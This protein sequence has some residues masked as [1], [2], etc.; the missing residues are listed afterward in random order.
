MKKSVFAVCLA[1]SLF[2]NTLGVFA[3]ETTGSVSTGVQTGAQ[4]VV[5]SE[6]SASPVAGTYTASQSVTLSATDA[7][8]L[9][10]TNDNTTP[11]CNWE[12]LS[13]TS[14]TKYSSALSLT[15]N[16]K[17]RAISCYQGSVSS[18]VGEYFYTIGAGQETAAEPS[19]STVTDLPETSGTSSATVTVSSATT[20]S[21]AA[22]LSDAVPS[23]GADVADS[24]TIASNILTIASS[25][26]ASN[27]VV[28]PAGTVITVG[29]G[30][31]SGV[32]NPPVSIADEAG[33]TT[34]LG[35]TPEI[36]VQMGDL[37]AK[38]DFGTTVALQPTVQ[39]KL[40]ATTCSA[41]GY[42][43]SRK[44]FGD[45]SYSSTGVSSIVAT[46]SGADCLITF[47]TQFMSKFAAANK[48]A[49]ASSSSSS[50][51][52]GGGGGGSVSVNTT[53]YALSA[54]SF[55]ASMDLSRPL[56]LK[57]TGGE[58]TRP[59]VLKNA[60][61]KYSIE[62]NKGTKVTYS[63][64]S[65]F[66]GTIMVPNT[67]A[68]ADRPETPE[69]FTLVRGMKVGDEEGKSIHFSEDV[70][71]TIPVTFIAA[72]DAS[73]VS[74]YYYDESASM[75]KKI[76]G[77]LSDD[78]KTIS[79]NI[80]HMTKFSVLYS[81]TNVSLPS[82]SDEASSTTEAPAALGNV[83][84]RDVST[85]WAKDYIVE[86][87]ERGVF[88]NQNNFRPNEALLRGELV[89]IIV[90]AFHIPVSDKM[91]PLRLKDVSISE[92]YAPYVSAAIKAGIVKGYEDHTF[93]PGQVVNRA[94]ALKMIL[95]ASQLSDFTSNNNRFTDV[96]ASSWYAKYV[97]FA[98]ENGI[99][100]GKTG[101]LFAPS[102]S[103]TRAEVSKIIMK[104]LD[105]EK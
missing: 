44:S 54:N 14:G 21:G 32:L 104:T 103:V 46:Q 39:L 93:R 56:S 64:G 49:A 80:N 100:R 45:A 3:G 91:E 97:Q 73:K 60:L 28:L 5:V 16:T 92:W 33:A 7:P 65:A 58:I 102:D 76:G 90:E 72:V 82:D 69:G 31:W 81:N 36:S 61:R 38:L 83:L 85:H 55:D 6:P 99:V 70:L 23:G 52:G 26:E 71:L 17:V 19:N 105:L 30:T 35:K 74:V 66:I 68:R 22:D 11:S 13:C 87:T 2:V 57:K 27:E 59:V 95:E 75:Y 98:Y 89:K 67:L 10:Y 84:F 78:Q 4:G 40:A 94:E 29:A 50:G 34:A 51:G 53:P 47:K 62:I 101:L 88:K 18:S 37:N 77:I 86:L 41:D 8:Y 42:N 63:D 43:I 15:T 12:A 48:E 79:V 1:L 20:V 96:P 9:C 24:V 25:A